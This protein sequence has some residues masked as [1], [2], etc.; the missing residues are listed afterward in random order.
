VFS[1]LVGLVG[2][3]LPF[4]R[5][6]SHGGC[7][8]GRSWIEMLLDSPRRCERFGG[9]KPGDA[10][11]LSD[12]VGLVLM[13]AI[14]LPSRSRPPTNSLPPLRWPAP[15]GRNGEA[16]AFGE[17]GELGELKSS[18]DSAWGDKSAPGLNEKLGRATGLRVLLPFP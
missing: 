6:G 11:P 10:N 9:W 14:E 1:K 16:M 2:A 18:G 7:R 4:M 5:E 12:F 3:L 8:D 17:T 13:T 15:A